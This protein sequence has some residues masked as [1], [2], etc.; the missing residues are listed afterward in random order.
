MMIL[1]LVAGEA[2][3]EKGTGWLYLGSTLWAVPISQ[4]QRAKSFSILTI[5]MEKI[6][7]TSAVFVAAARIPSCFT[8]TTRVRCINDPRLMLAN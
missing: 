3:F 4:D 2:R 8:R 1:M 5:L 7:H 6:M